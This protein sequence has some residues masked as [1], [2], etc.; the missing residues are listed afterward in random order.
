MYGVV[1]GWTSLSCVLMCGE[2]KCIDSSIECWERD[3]DRVFLFVGDEKNSLKASSLLG[4]CQQ[5]QSAY[6]RVKSAAAAEGKTLHPKSVRL[7]ARNNQDWVTQRIETRDE[8]VNGYYIRF[9][10][11]TCRPLETEG[12]KILSPLM[13]SVVS[14]GRP[15][16]VAINN[17]WKIETALVTIADSIRCRSK[18]R[19]TK[20]Q[21]F[22]GILTTK[23]TGCST[24][25]LQLSRLADPALAPLLC[26]RG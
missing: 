13:P 26:R 2:E 19:C 18:N 25:L 8:M 10:E 1:Q 17:M 7:H 14:L 12:I 6:Q 11:P 22:L 15:E 20:Q 4:V 23:R 3:G 9:P 16:A 21:S 5:A 24:Q